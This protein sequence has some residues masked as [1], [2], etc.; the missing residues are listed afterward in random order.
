MIHTVPTHS[1][2][3]P[4]KIITLHEKT[5]E[6]LVIPSLGNQDHHYTLGS[7]HLQNPNLTSDYDSKLHFGLFIT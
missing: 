4:R 3:P 5:S 7:L 2:S 6:R 1:K